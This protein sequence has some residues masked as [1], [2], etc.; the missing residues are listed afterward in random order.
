[1]KIFNIYAVKDELTGEF[2]QPFFMESDDVAKRTFAT[3]VNTISIWKE[4][5]TDFSLYRLGAFDQEQG[6][7]SSNIEKLVNGRAVVHD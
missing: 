1:M 7:I 2:L 5:A 3:N 6:G 4:N